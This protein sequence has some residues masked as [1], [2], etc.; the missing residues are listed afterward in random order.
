MSGYTKLFQSIVTSTIWSEGDRTRIV[1]I[2]MLAMANQHGEVEASIPGLAK[3]AGVPLEDCE[4]A[5]GVL[6]G[7]DPY[8]RTKDFE[9]RRI[10]AIDGGWRILNHGKY[11]AMASAEDRREQDRL[12][13]Q[14][15]RRCPQL[16]A[17]RPQKSAL[18]A[19]AEAE[20]EAEAERQK[21]VGFSRTLADTTRRAEARP[22]SEQ[23]DSEW[24]TSLKADKAYAGLD[25][26]REHARLIRWCHENRKEPTRRRFINWLNRCD[27]PLSRSEKP[28]HTKGF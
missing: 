21:D 13:K 6:S 2:T 1:W 15:V 27:K 3:L 26:E 28:D 14:R 11:R 16:S 12:R 5:L 8:S 23:S 9:G 17:P 22:T 18:S 24:L 25:I 19:Q 4:K 20:A 10:E 7:P